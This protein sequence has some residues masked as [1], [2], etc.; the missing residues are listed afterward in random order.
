MRWNTIID[1]SDLTGTAGL[2]SLANIL[3]LVTFL[4]MPILAALQS[5]LLS[6]WIMIIYLQIIAHMPLINS[7]MPSE[8]L[9]FL[10]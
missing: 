9:L 3:I 4:A 10:R 2:A 1:T 5:S 7:E 6:I 8:V